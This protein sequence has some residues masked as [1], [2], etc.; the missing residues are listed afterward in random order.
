MIDDNVSF[1]KKINE[2]EIDAYNTLYYK[3]YKSLVL[4]TKTFVERQDIAEDIVQDIIMYLWEHDLTFS[5]ELSLRVYLYNSLRNKAINHLNRQNVEN[6]Y[7]DYLQ[8]QSSEHDIID[9]EAFHEE[10]YRQLFAVLN[11]LP[12]RQHDIFLLH[13]AGKKNEEIAAELNI[14]VETVKTH[15]KRALITIRK[16]LAPFI[17]FFLYLDH[18]I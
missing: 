13:M 5:D 12:K 9:E 1:I 17:L 18:I 7:L 3:Y 8:T 10:V 4:Y 11:E 15:K 14:A 6:K 16:R 2:K